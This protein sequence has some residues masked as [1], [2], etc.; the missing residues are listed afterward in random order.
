[1]FG[2]EKK[3]VPIRKYYTGAISGG[4]PRTEE[5]DVPLNQ[6]TRSRVS[7]PWFQFLYSPEIVEIELEGPFAETTAK[8]Y[9]LDLNCP[10]NTIPG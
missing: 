2:A 4:G 7:I 1:M 5:S 3:V 9:C 6:K 10:S 8:S